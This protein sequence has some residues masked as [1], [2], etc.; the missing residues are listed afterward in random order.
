MQKSLFID[1][2]IIPFLCPMIVRIVKM[3]FKPEEVDNFKQ[4]FKERKEKIRGFPGCHYLELL[5]GA[6]ASPS[7]F[8]TYSYWASEEDLNNYR[9]SD[10]FAETWKLTKKMFSQKAEAISTQKLHSLS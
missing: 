4:L 10:L 7:T 3:Q 8:F 9:H 5:Q 2:P 6:P 1:E